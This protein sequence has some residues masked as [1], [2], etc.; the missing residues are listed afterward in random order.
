MSNNLNENVVIGFFDGQGPADSAIEALKSWDKANDEIKLGAIGTIAKEGDKVKT[1][2]GRKSGKGAAVGAT[3]GV[4]GAVLS[5]GATLIGGAV[6]M[7]ALGGVLG[8]FFKK[9]LHLNKEE[10][11]SIGLEL[12]GGKVAVVVS[13]DDFEVEPTGEQLK[14]AGGT[15][16]SYTIPEEALS[17][18]AG[19]GQLPAGAS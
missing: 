4:I 8:A 2:V 11:E 18:A 5:G 7:G 17:E 14:N 12:D 10:I 13:C 3:I 16:R 1:H 6:A 15:V 19:S 9:S